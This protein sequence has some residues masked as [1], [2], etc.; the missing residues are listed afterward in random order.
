MPG[1]QY[2]NLVLLNINRWY[3]SHHGQVAGRAYGCS[4]Q[5][6]WANNHLLLFILSRLAINARQT[7]CQFGFAKYQPLVFIAPW[8][9]CRSRLRMLRATDAGNL[10]YPLHLKHFSLI[11]P[12]NARAL[13]FVYAR[14]KTTQPQ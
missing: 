13:I 7:I 8:S 3:L 1:K 5:P 12:V 6:T 4:V 10:P 11:M 2:V 9:S 14:C